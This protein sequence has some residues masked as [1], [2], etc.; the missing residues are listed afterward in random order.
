MK[1]KFKLFCFGFGQVARYFVK[2]L[3]D[4]NYD[5]ELAATNT[6]KTQF[7]KFYN[8]KF[9]SFYFFNNKFD[10]KLLVELNKFDK[11]LISIPPRKQFDV[12]L[13]I[14]NQTEAQILSGSPRLNYINLVKGFTQ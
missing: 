8:K 13:R 12:V 6:T 2:N 1:K 11:V 10:E 4:K 3:V 7:R 5:F 9:K 14:F